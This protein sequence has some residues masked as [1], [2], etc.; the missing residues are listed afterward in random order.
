MKQSAQSASPLDPLD[1]KLLATLS[2]APRSGVLEL[3]RRL[4]IARNTVSSRLE[5]LVGSGVVV[6]FG[7]EVDLAKAGY[8][9]SA[10]VTLQIAQGRGT[11]VTAHLARLPQVVEVHRTTG[12]G[13]LLCRVVAL[14]NSHLAEVLDEIL[15]VR[16]I[17]RTT[18][19]LVLDTPVAPRVL[20]AID[21]LP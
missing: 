12:A 14:S 5:R 20:P 3:A 6:G 21:A 10:Y 8:R 4:G 17:T 18:T 9:V 11:E 16:G 13:D 1:R 19:S 15:K 7:P 2:D